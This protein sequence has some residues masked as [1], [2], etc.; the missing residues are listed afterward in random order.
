M[1]RIPFGELLFKN[2]SMH[3]VGSDDI[4]TSI[5]LDATRAL[6]AA[7]EDGW[8]GQHVA[9][10]VAL[11]QIAQAHERVER[12]DCPGRVIVVM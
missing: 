11:D 4:P 12:G 10:R 1:P 5:K 9:E 7:L 8:P 6:N 2:V 3:L